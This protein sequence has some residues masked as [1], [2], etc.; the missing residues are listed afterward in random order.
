MN[1]KELFQWMS[2][3]GVKTGQMAPKLGL[4]PRTLSGYKSKGLPYDKQLLANKVTTEWFGAEPLITSNQN[5]I[6]C[7]PSE[8]ERAKWEEAGLVESNE[9]TDYAIS[10]INKLADAVNGVDAQNTNIKI[11][12]ESKEA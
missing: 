11:G 2:F 3:N 8:L 6:K 9:F 5:A 10:R 7:Y 1:S 4:S 12:G